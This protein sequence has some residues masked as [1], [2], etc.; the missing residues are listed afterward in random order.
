[1]DFMSTK[2]IV[3]SSNAN[4]AG[5]SAAEK[6]EIVDP[7]YLFEESS[8]VGEGNMMPKVPGEGKDI[9]DDEETIETNNIDSDDDKDYEDDEPQITMVDPM[10]EETED[11]DDSD[12]DEEFEAK[13][14]GE[15]CA[16]DGECMSGT[17]QKGAC[18]KSEEP[19]EPQPDPIGLDPIVSPPEGDK[20]KP[21]EEPVTSPSPGDKDQQANKDVVAED[22]ESI[23]FEDFEGENVF[24]D[25]ILATN[26]VD[27]T[28][29]YGDSTS[30]GVSIKKTQSL[31]TSKWVNISQCKKMKFKFFAF[32]KGYDGMGEGF[33]IQSKL[34]YKKRGGDWV[35]NSWTVDGEWKTPLD[36]LDQCTQYESPVYN[37]EENTNYVETDR[38]TMKFLIRSNGNTLS[39][40][41]FI[42]DLSVI[43]QD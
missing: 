27:S 32:P 22:G 34:R 39:K 31:R 18:T 12:D 23:L 13:Q 11:L 4:S 1:V 43:C 41:V 21:K 25:Y 36:F 29:G 2:G 33:K 35:V 30:K 38:I 17:C 20:E 40:E 16:L 42:D 7:D 5:V 37:V 9:I 14:A 24:D 15:K 3:R 19:E 26:R 10:D 28:F 8:K 6:D